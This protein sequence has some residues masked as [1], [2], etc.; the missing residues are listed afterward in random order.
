M[1]KVGTHHNPSD[2]LTKSVQS[3]VLGNHLP[4]LNLFRDS[5]LSQVFKVSSI[6]SVHGLHSHR[7]SHVEDQRLAQLHQVCAQH[8]G[9]V[10]VINFEVFQN[11]QDLVI[12]RFRSASGRI[13]RAFTPPPPRR[14]SENQDSGHSDVQVQIQENQNHVIQNVSA[15]RKI[16]IMSFRMSQRP[17]D[18]G[19]S[20]RSS[21]QSYTSWCKGISSQLRSSIRGEDRFKEG[22]NQ[23]NQEVFATCIL[24]VFR[25][26]SS[27]QSSSQSSCLTAVSN[28]LESYHSQVLHLL[29]ASVVNFTSRM[30]A[31]PQPVNEAAASVA[32]SVQSMAAAHTKNEELNNNAQ[33]PIVR[34]A[35]SQVEST[36][37]D[38]ELQHVMDHVTVNTQPNTL[39][40]T[41]TSACSS[42]S[43]SLKWQIT[44]S[45]GMIIVETSGTLS[46]TSSTFRE[47][48]RRCSKSVKVMIDTI[49]CCQSQS[50][51]LG[52]RLDGSG[53]LDSQ[54]SSQALKI[55]SF[56]RFTCSIG[57]V[58][59]SI[60]C[61]TSGWL[62]VSCST[63]IPRQV[64]EDTTSTQGH[65]EERW[66]TYQECQRS[67]G[68]ASSGL[69]SIRIQCH[70]RTKSST[71][72]SSF[73]SSSHSTRSGQQRRRC[74]TSIRALHRS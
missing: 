13:R 59:P 48:S 57:S 33:A 12:Q 41:E 17:A 67:Q 64:M 36:Q 5:S 30:A 4:K 71:R 19:H 42:A 60:T 62:T 53:H 51:N 54:M 10:C 74:S 9:Q 43:S 31:A 28:S 72:R 52:R 58:M 61:T 14:G 73:T 6:V 50:V 27:N 3:S 29:S 70:T 47:T 46:A 39:S 20:L 11:Q 2:V 56:M 49:L 8:Q 32:K 26:M 69:S 45:N 44:L 38:Q 18:G 7:G 34:H 25:F 66:K 63:V 22:V 35:L 24:I 1:K 37:K 55:K 15:I 68:Q 23:D 65:S 21:R 16:K 40:R